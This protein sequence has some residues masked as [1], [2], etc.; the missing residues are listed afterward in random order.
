ME[1][2]HRTPSSLNMSFYSSVTE[3]L[4]K[5]RLE[6]D[7]QFGTSLSFVAVFHNMDFH[8]RETRH[9]NSP[10]L[11][12]HDERYWNIWS[13]KITKP[14]FVLIFGLYGSLTGSTLFETWNHFCNE[15]IIHPSLCKLI[16]ADFLETFFLIRTWDW[17]KGP[18][19]E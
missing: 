13:V 11:W 19:A 1:Y 17:K 18:N 16:L 4:E 8:I 6:C 5:F 14:A 2:T 10:L 7:I 15:L 9:W 3:C 12:G